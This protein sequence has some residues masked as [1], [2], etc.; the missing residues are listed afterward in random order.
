VAALAGG[1]IAI[2][3]GVR[4]P[5][6]ALVVLAYFRGVASGAKLSA[7][8]FG[9]RDLV[10]TVAGNAGGAVLGV[11]QHGVG[12]GADLYARVVMTTEAGSGGRLRR[13]PG[14]GRAR[15]AVHATQ[16]LVHAVRKGFRLY[17][18]GLALGINHAGAGSMA[19]KAVIC[20]S[21]RKGSYGE[22]QAQPNKDMKSTIP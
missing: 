18:D 16:I 6:N 4:A 10:R 1:R 15:V 17:R 2:Q 12:T 11:A 7:A 21:N 19:G 14:F 8:R 9:M 20:G 3:L 13:M 5:V 22:D